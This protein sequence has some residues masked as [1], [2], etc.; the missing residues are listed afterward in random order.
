MS[1]QVSYKKQTVLGIIGITIL[2]LAIEVIANVWWITQISCEFENNDIFQDMSADE[3]KKMCGELYNVRTSG[4]ELIPN[5]NSEFLN[6]NS[7]GF[8]GP[9]MTLIKPDDTYRIFMLGGSTMFGMG[10]TSDETT[11]PGYTQTL[12][13][14]LEL[15]YNVEIINA[16]IQ[17][18]NTKTE[19]SLTE[20]KI[21]RYNPDLIIMYDGWNDLREGFDID[22]TLNN[23]N[24]ICD[25][26]VTN[27]FETIVILQPI[28]GFG[29]KILTKQESTYAKT[30][31]DYKNNI[32]LDNISSYNTLAEQLSTLKTCS[33]SIDMRTGFDEIT[34][35]IYW[36]QGHTSDK[37]NF[38][39]AKLIF[40]EISKVIDTKAI[41][42]SDTF[43]KDFEAI[44]SE[45]DFN[46]QV[47]IRNVLSYYKTPLMLN[48]IFSNN[49][50]TVEH[51]THSNEI[52][53]ETKSKSYDNMEIAIQIKISSAINNNNDKII[54]IS[55]I[56][57]NTE[58]RLENITYFIKISK[59]EQ[60]I[61]REYFFSEDET[62][63]INISP[64]QNTVIEANGYRNYE[65]NALNDDFDDN[66]PITIKGPLF[67]SQ[68]EYN[69]TIDILTITNPK[70]WIFSL[71]DFNAQLSFTKNDNQNETIIVDTKTENK[72]IQTYEYDSIKFVSII[73]SDDAEKIFDDALKKYALEWM[74]G[75]I[76][77]AEFVTSVKTHPEFKSLYANPDI[78]GQLPEWLLN[79]AGRIA[80]TILTN[81]D[82]SITH[83]QYVEE[84][85]YPCN[86][87]IVQNPNFECWDIEINSQGLRS[88][89]IDENKSDEIFRIITLGGSTTYGGVSNEKTWPGHLQRIIEEYIPDKKIEVIN[90]GKMGATTSYELEFVKNKLLLL[91]PDLIIM[92]DGWND[93]QNEK[94]EKTVQNWK[95][96]CQISKDN[97]IATTIIIQPLPLSGQRVLT[98]QEIKS[99]LN[100]S[101]GSTH[102]YQ[103]ISQQYVDSLNELNEIC[104][105]T[106]DFRGIFDYI[107]APIYYDGGHILN[108]GNIILSSNIFTSIAPEFF[109]KSFIIKHNYSPDEFQSPILYAVKTDLQN[110]DMSKL[111][112][113]DAIFDKA[114][115]MNADFTNADLA[116]SRFVF[117]N[118][119]GSNLSAA[120]LSGVNLSGADMTSANVTDLVIDQKWLTCKWAFEFLSQISDLPGDR[121]VQNFV[122]SQC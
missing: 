19:R 105:L 75:K 54:E 63:V 120:N 87:K 77:D 85:I 96:V 38:I 18:A 60:D 115:L 2:L 99:V 101:L 43:E 30:G 14:T 112:L 57:K 32:L 69:F 33:A 34:E 7:H 82:V 36:D 55:T 86:E 52:I 74:T 17:N 12:V 15:G 48:S 61:L 119:S 79:N 72:K 81:G 45:R 10:A 66:I 89:E 29:N 58:Q 84:T 117:A 41:E 104:T 22:T 56:D 31:L 50:N 53:L 114:K 20:Q 73:E 91:D 71:T 76:T 94:I 118:L 102:E 88:Y 13:N 90:A 93:S 26:G 49:E 111:F 109:E 62:L 9:E 5:Q 80:A 97:D 64:N 35:P 68:E 6:V 39:I 11:I 83:H 121:T 103:R 108:H 51:D 8:R 40:G 67:T 47:S 92:Y 24:V 78:Q 100:P 1:V 70:N 23:W 16:G 25:L 28:A 27:N 37:G 21:I 98:D 46:L 59:N 42:Y 65:H 44:D 4:T 3:R 106:L 95:E 122:K 110:M 107:H 116:N 113:K